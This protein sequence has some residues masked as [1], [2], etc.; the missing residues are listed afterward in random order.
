MHTTTNTFERFCMCG[1]EIETG[2]T[3]QITVPLG[4]LMVSTTTTTTTKPKWQS[5]WK[6]CGLSF[7]CWTLHIRACHILKLNIAVIF[8]VSLESS[9]EHAHN[10]FFL[11]PFP[12]IFLILNICLLFLFFSIS[13]HWLPQLL[14][15]NSQ[16]WL[17]VSLFMTLRLMFSTIRHRL[18]TTI[19]ALAGIHCQPLVK[20]QVR[21]QLPLPT[22]T[23]P[24]PSSSTPVPSLVPSG[25]LS[26][27]TLWIADF[28]LVLLPFCLKIMIDFV[29]VGTS[30]SLVENLG[31]LT[32]VRC[33]SHKSG[34][35]HSYQCVQYFHVSRQWHG[36]QCLGFLT[37]TQM[38]MYAITHRVCTDT[39]SM[40]NICCS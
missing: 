24:P 19:F 6:N 7:S 8:Q 9:C 26:C 33:S 4:W 37:Y 16:G 21:D 40:D 36:S 38:L 15:G 1:A 35:T 10:L 3:L 13:E 30:L 29:V 32:W 11:P 28:V 17:T 31:H 27:C 20:V 2:N 12:P 5:V 25:A 22:P 39:V 34:A 23:P 18:V 14:F